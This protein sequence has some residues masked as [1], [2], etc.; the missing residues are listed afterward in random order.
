MK[1]RVIKIISIVLVFAVITGLCSC[2]LT[3]KEVAGIMTTKR[4]VTLPTSTRK[5]NKTTDFAVIAIAPE[6]DEAIIKYFNDALEIFYEHDFEFIKKK[7]TTLKEYSAGS[8]SNVSGATQSYLSTLKSACGDMMGVGSLETN[9]YFGDNISSFFEIKS[10]NKKL[11]SKCSAAAEGS[12]VT[13]G[14]HYSAD[15]G[16]FNNSLKTLTQDFMTLSDF[17][18]KISRYGARFEEAS[19]EISGIKLSAVI[20]YSTRHFVSVKIE[21]TTSFSVKEMTFDYISGGPVRGKTNTV[22]SYTEFKEK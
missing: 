11:V 6:G 5:D 17:T 12:N 3:H 13:I 1:N 7:T 14:F 22:I 10:V 4:Q 21:Y 18:S 15:S 8:L 9:F 20:D 2:K 19:A 16:D